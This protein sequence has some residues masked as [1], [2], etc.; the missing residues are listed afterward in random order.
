MNPALRVIAV[1][2]VVST[3]TFAQTAATNATGSTQ[4]NAGTA[5]AAQTA[6]AS[7]DAQAQGGTVVP[8]VLL[9]SID[10]KK[11]KV[12]DEV[13]AKVMSDIRS[14]GQVVLPR[15]SKLIGK[16]TQANARAKGDATSTL[17]ITFDRA[18]L[19]NGSAL[20]LTSTIQALVAPPPEAP[21]SD[22]SGMGS[23]GGAG[24][25]LQGSNTGST[26]GGPLSGA[27]STVG[28]VANTAGSTVSGVASAAGDTAASAAGA[29]T[30]NASGD[31]VLTTR[32]SGVVGI[33]NLELDSSATAQG[34]GTV[35]TS[36][37]KS[38]KVDSGSRLLVRITAASPA[39][40]APAE[41]K[42][43]ARSDKPKTDERK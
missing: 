43:K 10:S 2:A 8:A 37:S 18:V 14:G 9:K 34:A 40:S 38:V 11:A 3:F 1:L 39:E 24:T 35:F 23:G 33:K 30:R 36:N 20:S 4:T 26:A 6:A 32:T 27:A 31:F 15:D 19:K 42:E 7:A 12:G 25:P 16:I 29:A 13:T 22:D 41:S 21:Y 5:N 17:G 28:G